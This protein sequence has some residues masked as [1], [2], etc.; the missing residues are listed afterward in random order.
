MPDIKRISK[1]DQ[2]G[3]PKFQNQEEAIGYF[4]KTYGE[5]SSLKSRSRQKKEIA[6]F[7]A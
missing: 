5:N 7:T 1:E 6:I 3:L 2:A 4:E